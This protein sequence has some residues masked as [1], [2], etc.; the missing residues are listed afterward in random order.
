M[1]TF[2]I[3][4]T[5]FIVACNA[6]QSVSSVSPSATQNLAAGDT[7]Y[8][9]PFLLDYVGDY[10]NGK[11]ILPKDEQ[12]F[13]YDSNDSGIA[14]VWIGKDK[15]RFDND[16]ADIRFYRNNFDQVMALRISWVS[17]KKEFCERKGSVYISKWL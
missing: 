8:I 16:Q 14:L 9:S 12:L 1:K 13:Y 10:S 17:G 6:P 15:F 7:M 2:L 11:N 5:V 4:L 3:L